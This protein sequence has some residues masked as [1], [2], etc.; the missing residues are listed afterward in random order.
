M[1]RIEDTHQKGLKKLQIEEMRR[2]I[3]RTGGN[4]GKLRELHEEEMWSMLQ[5]DDSI[6]ENDALAHVISLDGGK[7]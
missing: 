6:D 1:H 3:D 5:Q 7:W 4:N 2:E